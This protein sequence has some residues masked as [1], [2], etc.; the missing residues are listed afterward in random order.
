LQHSIKIQ[1]IPITADKNGNWFGF[2][3]KIDKD[4]DNFFHSNQNTKLDFA[5]LRGKNV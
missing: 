5:D 3:S 2:I 4:G 1:K